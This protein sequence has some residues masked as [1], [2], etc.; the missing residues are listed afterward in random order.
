[1]QSFPLT[2]HIHFYEWDEHNS[3]FH[4]NGLNLLL[5][6]CCHTGFILSGIDFLVLLVNV[7][8]IRMK[9]IF[10][11]LSRQD[12]NI[13][14]SD[15]T[16]KA[17]LEKLRTFFEK[18]TLKRD[19]D[20]HFWNILLNKWE[21]TTFCW[22]ENQGAMSQGLTVLYKLFCKILWILLSCFPWHTGYKHIFSLC[23]RCYNCC[24]FI[25]T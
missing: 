8:L 14:F 21:Y 11:D 1:M 10:I 5:Q 17:S 18:N 15:S 24:C 16:V 13:T 19:K 23:F 4:S 7:V 9:D 2:V 3:A 6:A 25:L 20:I 22:I 12:K